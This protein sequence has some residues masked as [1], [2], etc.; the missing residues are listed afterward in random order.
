MVEVLHRKKDITKFQILVEI[1]AHQP[2]IKQK[3]IAEKIGVTPQAVSEYIKELIEEGLVHSDGRVSYTVTSRGI[4]WIQETA[5]ELK[6]YAEYVVEDVI[7][8]VAVWTAIADKD[9]DGEEKVSVYMRDGLLW[10]GEYDPNLPA[11]GI[12]IFPAS[13]GEDVGIKDLKGMIELTIKPVKIGRV[14]RVEHGGSRRVDIEKVRKI[15]EECD[16]TCAIG[17]ESLIALRKAGVEADVMFGAS[18]SVVEAA[19]HG[20]SVF[21]LCLNDEVPHLLRRLENEGTRYETVEILKEKE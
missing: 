11:S 16:Y 5:F 8:H 17:V 19:Q 7:S 14:P 21:V 3:K 1:A 15:I 12:T 4:E 2:N 10:A 13:K 20:L 9:V 6:R 18:G